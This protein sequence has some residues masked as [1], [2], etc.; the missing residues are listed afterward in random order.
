MA[1][2]HPKSTPDPRPAALW[3]T[4]A[5]VIALTMAVVALAVVVYVRTEPVPAPS[6]PTK[7]VVILV[8]TIKAVASVT[9]A[10]E[11][12]VS[13]VVIEGQQKWERKVRFGEEITVQ[14]A[15]TGAA[16]IESDGEPG[17]VVCSI[18]G[19]DRQ[20]LVKNRSDQ[21][22]ATAACRWANDGS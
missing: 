14:A 16:E 7:E 18:S 11:S 17:S 3:A 22:G 8:S 15:I 2:I 9:I 13:S 21:I 20:V 12:G 10:D 5:A 6:G 19:D 4:F 1:E